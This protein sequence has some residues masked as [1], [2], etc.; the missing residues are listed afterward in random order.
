MEGVGLPWLLP[1]LHQPI[2]YKTGAASLVDVGY[3]GY[4]AWG[5]P[6]D[7]IGLVVG[8][9]LPQTISPLVL[10]LVVSMDNLPLESW[11]T[12]AWIGL[13]FF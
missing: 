11:K 9:A 8:L 12:V 7:R 5:C 1:N 6:Q 10:F 2:W 3:R 4:H 13:K